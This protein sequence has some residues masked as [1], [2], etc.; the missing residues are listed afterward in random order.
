MKLGYG[1]LKTLI[2]TLKY[3]NFHF[4]DSLVLTDDLTFQRTHFR[5]TPPNIPRLYHHTKQRTPQNSN[6]HSNEPVHIE[7]ITCYNGL[8]H[9]MLCH[10]S[11][12]IHRRFHAPA[13]THPKYN[14]QRHRRRP[15]GTRQRNR[16]TMSNPREQRKYNISNRQ[17]DIT[18]ILPIQLISLQQLC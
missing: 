2:Q 7:N 5:T 13:H 18:A 4:N 1:I 14:L 9:I 3:K 16:T 10:T 6:T 15:N 8:R 11:H 12:I 17:R